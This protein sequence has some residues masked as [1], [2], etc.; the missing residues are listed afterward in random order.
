MA[1]HV[2]WRGGLYHVSRLRVRGDEIRTV[3]AACTTGTL[4]VAGIGTLTVSGGLLVSYY[5]W[6]WL[7][8]T[9]AT[10]IVRLTRRALA[11]R[12]LRKRLTRVLVVGSSARAVQMW[13]H[14]FERHHH[15]EICIGRL[16]RHSRQRIS[17]CLGGRTVGR[18]A[19]RPESTLMREPVDEVWIALPV[20]SHYP[21]IQQALHVCV[22]AWA[23]AR[24]TVRTCFRRG[25]VAAI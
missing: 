17:Q 21:Q 18:V 13:A 2:W 20:K 9:T 19:R 23:S 14:A 25:G 16:R 3:C 1:G 8:T 10:V 7:G 15:D 6:F 24:S 5:L 12:T 22:N 4:L 11:A